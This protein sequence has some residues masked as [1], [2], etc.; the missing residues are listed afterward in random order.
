MQSMSHEEDPHLIIGYSLSRR[1][2]VVAII[3]GLSLV[4]TGCGKSGSSDFEEGCKK[5][6]VYAQNR[7]VPLGAAE[8]KT[9][10][11]LAAKIGGFAGNEMVAVNGWTHT[12][13]PAYP[14]NSPP[15]N[16]NVWFHL[17]N[18]NGWVSFAGVRGEPITPDP[19]GLNEGGRP[20]PTTPECEGKYK[21]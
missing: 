21:P 11:V 8:R 6:G 18:S 5:F 20:A 1:R 12:D 16:S 19:T 14:T 7:W 17:A 2:A 4:G 9:P 3:A 10:D 15:W 13:T